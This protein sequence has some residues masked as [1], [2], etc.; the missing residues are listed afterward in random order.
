[1]RNKTHPKTTFPPTPP[2]FLSSTSSIVPK[3]TFTA[4]LLKPRRA[5]TLQE[6]EEEQSFNV[7]YT[8]VSL[9]HR[10]ELRHCGSYGYQVDI[11]HLRDIV[12]N[13]VQICFL[14][15]HIALLQHFYAIYC[16]FLFH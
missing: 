3:D 13:F 14:Y 10:K 15:S 1:M 2:S 6:P 11:P 4:E 9:E 16:Y 7:T 12:F 8:K 5:Q